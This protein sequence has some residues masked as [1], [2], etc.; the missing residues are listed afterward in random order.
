M[1]HGATGALPRG[2]HWERL[3]HA[4]A[5]APPDFAPQRLDRC[6]TPERDA[7]TEMVLFDARNL[8]LFVRGRLYHVYCGCGLH[9]PSAAEQRPVNAAWMF[10]IVL[11]P[12]TSHDAGPR[13]VS[14][15]AAQQS[16]APRVEVSE[17]GMGMGPVDVFVDT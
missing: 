1:T 8:P 15:A 4:A 7:E 3:R 6:R 12:C 10:D 16:Y 17:L 11:R 13:A 5:V 14:E 2:T 9:L